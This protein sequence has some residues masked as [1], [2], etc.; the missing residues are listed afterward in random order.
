[1]SS[2]SYERLAALATHP[3]LQ[4]ISLEFFKA[5]RR[6]I[7]INVPVKL[8]SGE[9][10]LV[11]GHRVQYD[12]TLGPTKGGMRI[13]PDADG[14]EVVEL[15]FLMTLKTSLVGL[16]YGGAKGALQIDPKLYTPEDLESI[17]RGFARQLA[18]F[19]GEDVDIPAPDVNTNADTMRIMLDE[20]EKT[21]GK[22]SPATFTG[23]HIDDGGTLGR[24]EATGQGGFYVLEAFLAG[25]KP[26]DVRVAIQG[27]GNVGMHLAE[28]LFDRG[29]K[30]VAVSDSSSGL[31]AA[32]GLPVPALVEWKAAKKRFADYTEA[33][34]ITNDDVLLLECDVLAPSALGGVIT[35]ANVMGVRASI[36]LEMANG[37]ITPEADAMLHERGVRVVPDILANAGGVI[38]SYFEWL[39]NKKNEH[40][41]KERVNEDLK[42]MILDAIERLTQHVDETTS[43]RTA[44]YI[45]AIKRIVAVRTK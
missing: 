24:E 17:V 3:A 43:L 35:Q 22:K 31:Y 30:V 2:S 34:R 15:A 36:I 26:E 33:E 9:E 41:T 7:A 8:A 37:P 18:P 45:E 19:I 27:F 14:A 42:T 32:D 6:A 25:Q 21:V 20:Y 1:M 23:K 12:D 38:V 10:V 13:H 39:Q 28:L 29:Y 16:P 11:S 4:N 5:P 40:W 44:A